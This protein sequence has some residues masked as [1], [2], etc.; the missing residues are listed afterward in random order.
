MKKLLIVLI[1]AGAAFGAWKYLETVKD[2]TAK[3]QDKLKTPS[4]KALKE[5]MNK[6]EGK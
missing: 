4:E 2:R 3:N 6:D 1:L 5:E